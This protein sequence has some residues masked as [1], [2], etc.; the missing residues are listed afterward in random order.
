[1]D[2]YRELRV[3]GRGTFGAATLVEE[4]DSKVASVVAHSALAAVAPRA[5]QALI[6]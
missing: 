1:M 3:V 5:L 4:L 6:V 2:R